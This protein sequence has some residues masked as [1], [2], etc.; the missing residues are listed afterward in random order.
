MRRLP[1]L[2]IGAC[3]LALAACGEPE[4][5]TLSIWFHTGKPAERETLEAQVAAFEA[6]HPELTV[7]LTMIPEASYNQQ[8]QAAAVAGKLPDVL[9][10]DGPYLASY[11]W[12]G[13]LQPLDG[14]LSAELRDELLPSIIAQGTWNDQFWGVGTFDSGL[15]LYVNTDLLPTDVAVPD[16]PAEAWTSAAFSEL[17]ME[18]AAAERAAGGDGAVIDLHLNYGGGEWWTY[19]FSPVLQSAGADLIDRGTLRA[20]GT[21]DSPPAIAALETIQAWITAGLVDAN[22][23]ERAFVDGRVAFSWSGHWDHPSYAQAVGDALAVTPLPD[24]GQGSRTGMGSW[25]WAVSRRSSQQAAAAAFLSH[26]L[27]TE[28]VLRMSAANGAVPATTT[29]ITASPLYGDQGPLRLFAEQLRSSAVP[30]PVTPAYPVITAE[31]QRAFDRLIDGG[32]VAT[33]LGEAAAVIDREV[34]DNQGYP[35]E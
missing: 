8:V 10:L 12:Q 11:A 13:H 9:D 26:L 24:F 27:Q 32:D 33:A 23:D 28:E 25:A 7:E 30:R 21:L 19:A 18:L 6:A 3:L 17:L 1:V 4:G 22:T 35:L 15:G 29:A 16:S 5:E 20:S 2:S 34:A 14:L 31:F